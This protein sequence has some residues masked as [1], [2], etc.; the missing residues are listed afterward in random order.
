MKF[1]TSAVIAASVLIGS[2]GV[3]SAPLSLADLFKVSTLGGH[4]F[5]VKQF[6]N[7]RY[8]Q[9]RRG[10]VDLARAYNKFGATLPDNLQ[11]LIDEILEELRRQKNGK[12]RGK[13]NGGGKGGNRNGNGTVVVIPGTNN[14]DP[15][16]DPND[17]Q[18]M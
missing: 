5:R 14:T 2:D 18:G 1:S 16:S 3:F 15:N 10:A 11:S 12:G 7:K 9:G 6:Q 4:T 8:S 17:G 13:G